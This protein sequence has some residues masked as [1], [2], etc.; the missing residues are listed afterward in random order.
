MRKEFTVKDA[1]EILGVH[2]DTIKYWEENGLIPPARRN[3]GNRYRVYSPE[4][5][6]EIA[7]SRGIYEAEVN[8]AIEQKLRQTVR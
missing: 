4:E 5:I 3:K 2:K 8:S 7:R 1:A 6:R